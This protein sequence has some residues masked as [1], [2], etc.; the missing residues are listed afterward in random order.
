MA[1]FGELWDYTKV[2]RI[3]RALVN[4]ITTNGKNCPNHGISD[5][6]FAGAMLKNQ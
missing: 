4:F 5:G 3:L 1:Y 6:I 2:M